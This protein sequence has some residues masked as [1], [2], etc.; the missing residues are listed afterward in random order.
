MNT[1]VFDSSKRLYEMVS[2]PLSVVF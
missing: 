2:R 1:V